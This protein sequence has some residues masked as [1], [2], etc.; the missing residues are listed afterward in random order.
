MR[1]FRSSLFFSTLIL[2]TFSQTTSAQEQAVGITVIKTGSKHFFHQQI[3]EIKNQHGINAKY[4]AGNTSLKNDDFA[5]E[6]HVPE[7]LIKQFL[8]SPSE[9]TVGLSAAAMPIDTPIMEADKRFI[10]YKV[11]FSIKD[12][13]NEVHMSVNSYKEQ[14]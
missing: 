1:I 2:N 3:N 6:G 13:S 4:H 8:Q 11:L 7:N 5:F 10:T 14:C 12:V 9:S